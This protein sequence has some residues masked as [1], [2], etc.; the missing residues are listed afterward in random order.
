VKLL[1]GRRYGPQVVQTDSDVRLLSS[2]G[3]IR[4]QHERERGDD[5]NDDQDFGER[6]TLLV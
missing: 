1:G 3:A 4:E 6:E 2:S 5:R